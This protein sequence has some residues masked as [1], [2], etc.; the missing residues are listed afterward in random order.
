M[1][2]VTLRLLWFVKAFWRLWG[3]VVL[4]KVVVLERESD[5]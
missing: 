2:W 5:F 1:G 4:V 3:D